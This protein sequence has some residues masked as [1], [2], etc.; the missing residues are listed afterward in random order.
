[1]ELGVDLIHK[2]KVFHFY[3]L[4]DNI[5]KGY[6]IGWSHDQFYKVECKYIEWKL[7]ALLMGVVIKICKMY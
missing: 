3:T 7:K 6:S 2:N 4:L 5:V 1:M